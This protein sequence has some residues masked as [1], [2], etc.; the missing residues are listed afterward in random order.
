MIKSPFPGE[1]DALARQ[2]W[3]TWNEMLGQPGGFQGW[4]PPGGLPGGMNNPFAAAGIGNNPFANNPFAA[5]LAGM[6]GVGGGLPPGMVGFDP[7]AFEWYQQMQRLAADFSSG[8]ARAAEVAAAWREMMGQERSH[9]FARLLRS[10]H[11][12]LA[13]GNWLEQVRPM[14]EVLLKPLREQGAKWLQRPA[15]GPMREHQERLQALAL[16]WQEWEQRNDE[17]NDL[18]GRV[19]Q[20]ALAR[21]EV[22]L[23]ECD[24]PGKRLE[25][26]RALFDLWIEAAE[27]AWA[28][29]A[30]TDE[31]RKAYGEMTNAMMRVRLGLQGEVER[32]SAL[33]GMPGRTE[34]DALARKVA[35]L[36]RAQYQ[37]RRA[38]AQ[39][40]G[41]GAAA[42]VARKPVVAAAASAA[43]A[44]GPVAVQAAAVAPVARPVSR[45]AKVGS[46]Q[47]GAKRARSAKTVAVSRPAPPRKAAGKRKPTPTRAPATPP[48]A[49]KAPARRTPAKA[50]RAARPQASAAAV[51]KA[52]VER[53]G[54]AGRKAAAGSAAPAAAKVV[55]MKD[56]VNRNLPGI[57]PP[58][59]PERRGKSGRK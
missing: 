7:A 4:A 24:E 34:V 25:S 48:A 29:L 28:E 43:A 55:S 21:F 50:T 45:S 39:A 53:P 38:A 42:T 51:R 54:G 1:F 3:N 52:R 10:M 14:L 58:V 59:A 12:G 20:D 35:E 46:A 49:A 22:M 47:A 30:F 36:E 18:L 44:P 26:A 8:S 19:G 9:S 23:Q 57:E 40:A 5:S 2:Y 16:A 32:M 31:Y 11:G 17:F 56:W 6:G 13:G 15:F 41:K 37:A 27:E 33:L